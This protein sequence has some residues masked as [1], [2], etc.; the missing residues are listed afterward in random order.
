MNCRFIFTCSLTVLLV[1]G[2]SFCL[3][4]ENDNSNRGET[5]F[6]AKC[7]RCH[8]LS[9]ALSAK[10]DLAGWNATTLRMSEKDYSD[11]TAEQAKLV[12]EYLNSLNTN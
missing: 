4:A 2:Y 5:I 10:K 8:P 7:H 3:R 11:I 9:R 1:F 12:A 6:V